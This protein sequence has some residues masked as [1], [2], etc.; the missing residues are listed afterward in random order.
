MNNCYLVIQS[1]FYY[2]F[3]TTVSE[4]KDVCIPVKAFLDAS[5]AEEECLELNI[6]SF[7]DLI[8]MGA[9]IEH[10]EYIDHVLLASSLK[11]D[12]IFYKAFGV[13]ATDWFVD[14]ACRHKEFSIPDLSKEEWK[15]F[16][17]CFNFNFFRVVS[18]P[19]AG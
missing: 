12:K 9:I 1:N 7:S 16:I 14:T 18:V 17:N 13:S 19:L 3:A 6:K 11:E 5:Q 8:E 15:Y 10:G 2:Q 4:Q